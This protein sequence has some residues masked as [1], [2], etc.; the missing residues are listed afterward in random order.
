MSTRGW[1]FTPIVFPLW[2]CVRVFTGLFWNQS[3]PVLKPLCAWEGSIHIQYRSSLL[4]YL[5]EQWRTHLFAFVWRSIN[6]DRVIIMS[7]LSLL[8]YNTSRCLNIF[9]RIYTY[10]IIM[11]SNSI[12]W[13]YYTRIVI[14]KHRI[15]EYIINDI[16]IPTFCFYEM[17]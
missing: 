3:W 13:C 5:V 16:Y 9:I 10:N 1:W 7:Y 17:V 11:L 6:K 15:V 14:N 12:Y 2:T 4:S 8:L